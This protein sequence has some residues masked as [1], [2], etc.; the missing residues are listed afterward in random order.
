MSL[1]LDLLACPRCGSRLEPRRE[2]APTRDEAVLECDDGHR[3]VA[4]AGVVRLGS[5]IHEPREGARLRL[6]LDSTRGGAYWRERFARSTGR[7][8]EA[9]AGKTVLEW[10]CG[11]G[12]YTEW[13]AKYAARL[14]AFDTAGFGPV[15]RDVAGGLTNVTVVSGDASAPPFP[16]RR[17][18]VVVS[19]LGMSAT[20]A[21]WRSLDAAVRALKVDGELWLVMPAY[22]RRLHPALERWRAWGPRLPEPVVGAAADLLAPLAAWVHGGALHAG[23]RWLLPLIDGAVPTGSAWYSAAL[24]HETLQGPLVAPPYDELR[25][26][27]RRAGLEIDYLQPDAMVL[28]ARKRPFPGREYYAPPQPAAPAAGGGPV[29]LVR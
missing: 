18:D 22:R 10:G 1:S 28:R 9:L 25:R 15:C 23:A 2:P 14:V 24:Y 21:P 8:V 3:Y 27:C 6:L 26:W 5:A 16:A 29:R 19:V 4:H 13:L 20:E 12:H 17:F 11:P 7:P